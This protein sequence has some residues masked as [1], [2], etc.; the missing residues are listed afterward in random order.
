MHAMQHSEDDPDRCHL[1]NID[2]GIEAYVEV[3]SIEPRVVA[4]VEIEFELDT[5]EGGFHADKV[6]F[7]N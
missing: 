6:Y 3:L 2:N 4:R 5:R 7:S 1:S